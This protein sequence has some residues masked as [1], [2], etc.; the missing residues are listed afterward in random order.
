MADT[1]N[2]PLDLKKMKSLYDSLDDKQEFIDKTGLTRSALLE[3]I[4]GNTSPTVRTLQV[5][6]SYFGLRCTDLFKDNRPYSFS[7]K[8]YS[9]CLKLKDSVVLYNE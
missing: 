4:K 3:A 1:D 8:R 5:F 7:G 2:N 9:K 6:A